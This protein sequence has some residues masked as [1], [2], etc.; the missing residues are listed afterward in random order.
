MSDKLPK[1]ELLYLMHFLERDIEESIC[2]VLDDSLDDPHYSAV[3]TANMIVCYIM[4]MKALEMPVPYTDVKG[5]F[6][7][8]HFSEEDF[9]RFETSRKKESAYYA[10]YQWDTKTGGGL[11]EP[12]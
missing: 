9:L 3:T 2:G 8:N 10:G 5:Y 4:S 1:N 6:F 7:Y 12:F 11:R